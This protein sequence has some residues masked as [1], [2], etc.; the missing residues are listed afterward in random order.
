M[1]GKFGGDLVWRIAYGMCLV[2]LKLV[3]A[4]SFEGGA[5]QSAGSTFVE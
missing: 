4:N 3:E 1:A 5:S 2:D